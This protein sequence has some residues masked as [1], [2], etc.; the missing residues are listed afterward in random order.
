MKA[1]STSRMVL[2]WRLGRTIPPAG[3]ENDFSP[4]GRTAAFQEAICEATVQSAVA[5]YGDNLKAIVLTG[6]LARQ[7]GTFFREGDCWIQFGDSEFL[8][9]FNEKAKL[10][11]SE[12]LF[13]VQET[14]E[15]ELLRHGLK[16]RVS[17]AAV[18]PTYLRRLQPHIFAYELLTCG[19]V[20]WGE[21]VISLI[22][23]FFPAAI[24]HED[25]WRLLCNRM[26]ELLQA[27]VVLRDRPLEL[28]SE[29]FYQ[30]VKLYIDMGTSFLVFAGNYEPTF[31]A[32]AERIRLLQAEKRP[33]DGCPLDL[34][35]FA[36]RVDA[37]TRWKLSGAWEMA[38]KERVGQRNN[39]AFW[40]AA[41]ADAHLL[42]HWELTRLTGAGESLSDQQLIARWTRQ[43]PVVQRARGWLFVLRREG[44]HRSWRKWP[45]WAPRV[46]RASP[47][48]CVYAAASKLFFKLPALVAADS[49]T[50]AEENSMRQLLFRLP[51]FRNPSLTATPDWRRAA[52]EIAWN[53][54]RFLEGTRS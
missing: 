25:A 22:P 23:R 12:D 37:C 29:V 49:Q 42:W 17:L 34:A 53:Y 45:G 5:N 43:Q 30:A 16:C 46:L 9:V 48:Y 32:R 11:L 44:W 4:I 27:S 50:K 51:V 54:H 6:S 2:A 33:A 28:T 24:P 1:A 38:L 15:S 18:L 13:V 39:L 21:P 19:R 41:I 40:E 3:G 47:R 14:I 20:L 31:A 26:I 10:P 36:E 7:E 52:S 8:L 35:R